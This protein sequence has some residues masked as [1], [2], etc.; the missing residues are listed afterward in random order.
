[1]GASAFLL[2]PISALRTTLFLYT[3][4]LNLTAVGQVAPKFSSTLHV[5]DIFNVSWAGSE[6]VY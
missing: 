1:M 5:K 2:L 4:D 3:Q 6:A